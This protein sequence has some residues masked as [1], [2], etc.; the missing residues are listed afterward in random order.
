MILYILFISGNVILLGLFVYAQS[1]DVISL[2]HGIRYLGVEGEARVLASMG[3]I[4]AKS[5]GP[6]NLRPAKFAGRLKIIKTS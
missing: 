6:R 4:A 1:Y 2:I 5:A 3:H